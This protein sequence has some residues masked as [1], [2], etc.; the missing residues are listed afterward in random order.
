M[1][2]VLITRM[3]VT[4]PSSMTNGGF[5]QA[6]CDLP[7]TKVKLS[8]NGGITN[9][10]QQI[11]G[12]LGNVLQSSF[13][14]I[15][16]GALQEAIRKDTSEGR[17]HSAC[18]QYNCPYMFKSGN[19]ADVPVGKY[20]TQLEIDIPDTQCNIGG[21]DPRSSGGA[22]VMCRRNDP[23]WIAETDRLYESLEKI[24]F[25]MPHL[26]TIHVQGIAEPFYKDHIFRILDFL[27]F[28]KHKHILLST[29]TNGTLINK[30]NRKKFLKMCPHSKLG[31][32]IDAATPETYKKIRKIKG[33]ELITENIRAYAKEREKGRQHVWITNNINTF[34]VH[35]T[36]LMTEMAHD[37]GVD[38]IELGPT[39][40][41]HKLS[42]TFMVNEDNYETFR[43]AE[44][45]ARL[46]AKEIG[47]PFST[48]SPLTMEFDLQRTHPKEL[49]QIK[50]A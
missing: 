48:C 45:D 18:T 10:C 50:L 4:A 27:E 15:W 9:C 24:K 2:S 8:S 6:F 13:D 39:T 3:A 23:N 11:N 35:E 46:R 16:F 26:Q 42:P 40:Y 1:G 25:L 29:L 5:M 36:V 43:K 49:V 7:F 20:P 41:A 38:S 14:D 47:I 28:H 33:F 30:K 12:T 19:M 31:L 44:I 22:C 37:L 21:E 34:N 32:S 17:L